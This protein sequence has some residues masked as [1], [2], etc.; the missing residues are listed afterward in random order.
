VKPICGPNH[1]IMHPKAKTDTKERK[2]VVETIRPLMLHEVSNQVAS[3]VEA[4]RRKEV[5]VQPASGTA[6]HAR[7]HVSRQTQA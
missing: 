7:H 1:P 6:D 3:N 2:M 5:P 4:A